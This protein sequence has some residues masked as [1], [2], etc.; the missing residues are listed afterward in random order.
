M[1]FAVVLAA[2][3]AAAAQ[4]VVTVQVGGSATSP[5]LLFAPNNINATNG[6][7][8]NFQFTGVPGNHSVTQSTFASPCEPAPGGFDSGWIQISSAPSATPEWNVTITNDNVPIWFFCKQ[9]KSPP[10]P[11]CVAGMV[12]AINVKPGANSLQAF[13]A[14][15]KAATTVGQFEGSGGNIGNGASASADP[16]VPSGVQRFVGPSGTAPPAQ[17]GSG[18]AS[19]SGASSTT[20]PKPSAA[21]ALGVGSA[22]NVVLLVG[23]VLAGAAIVL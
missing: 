20:S 12:G 17:S 14:N 21:R 23:G 3:A 11:H 18:S 6:T 10:G 1:R 19:G 22:L 8:I 7:I 15:A 13:E 16:F 9:I 5:A 2:A 4:S